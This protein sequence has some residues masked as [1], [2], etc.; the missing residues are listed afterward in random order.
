MPT[1]LLL[2]LASF[3]VTS[4]GPQQIKVTSLATRNEQ[5][6]KDLADAIASLPSEDS[7]E[8]SFIDQESGR[9]MGPKR[10]SSLIQKSRDK[11][12]QA[13]LFVT[14]ERII[15]ANKGHSKIYPFIGKYRVIVIPVQFSDVKFDDKAF[16]KAN[17]DGVSL[18]QDYIFGDNKNSMA[19][20]YQ[21]AS[22]GNLT[23]EGE[24]TPIIT[25]DKTLKN[26]GE[27]IVGKSDRNANGLVMDALKKLKKIKTDQAWWFKYDTW[28]LSDYDQDK[29]FHEPDGFIDAVV[30]IYAGKSQASCQY[31]FDSAGTRPA[32][33][34]VPEGPRQAVA[35]EC[36]DK[37]WPHRWNINVGRDD[38]DYS[39]SGPLVEG[40]TR[41]SM[42]GLK[43]NDHLFASDYNM[44]SEFSDRSTFIHEF[45]HS[46]S[47]P[48]VYSAGKGNSTGSWEVMSQNANLQA[49]EMSS[50]SKISLGWL[51]PKIIEQGE[52]TSAYLGAYNYVSHDQRE[53]PA[54]YT[55]PNINNN[56]ESILSV[57][58][59]SGEN[60]YRSIMVITDPTKENR[61]IIEPKPGTGHITAYSSRFNGAQRSLTFAVEVPATGE[62]KVSFDTIYHIET[63]T[64][65]VSKDEKIKVVT[66][67]DIGQIIINEK[68]IEKLRIVS[69]DDNYNTLNEANPKCNEEKVLADRIKLIA[70]KL[71]DEEKS[72][73]KKEIKV[74]QAPVWVNKSY[75]LTA[76][77][78]QTIKFQINYVTD[79]GYTEFGIVVDNVKLPSGEVIDFED[80]SNLG[81]FQALTDGNEVISFNQYYLMEHRLP[82]TN[83]LSD[84][85]D[86][87]YNMD[88]NIGLGE[89]SMFIDEGDTI[90]ERFRMV[91]FDYQPGVLVWYFNSKFGRNSSANMPVENKGKGYLLV[92]NSKVQE[93]KLPGI[94]S[95]ESLLDES[96]LAYPDVDL[97]DGKVEGKLEELVKVQRDIFTCF[98]Y[99][100]YATAQTGKA[101][102][103]ED[104]FKDYMQ[105]LTFEGKALIYRRERFNDILP[106]DRY[107]TV[108]VGKPFR[109]GTSIRTGLSTFRPRTEK[110]FSPFKVY[111][112]VEGQ[113]VLDTK[114]TDAATKIE[115]V[116]KYNDLNNSLAKNPLF[117]GDTVVVEKKGFN[118]EVVAPNPQIKARYFDNIDGNDNDSSLRAPRTKVYFMWK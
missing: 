111:K 57:V 50:Y 34:D 94:F 98:A 107:A 80:K 44:Q 103:C 33:A 99:T 112:E 41:P 39:A 97:T 63:E 108:S 95:D 92:V 73:L 116:A 10:R 30:L 81:D 36:F 22:L 61:K 12:D 28:D 32:S 86:A 60:V 56:D 100:R 113:M 17:A 118:F 88:N 4:C 83:Y 43:I 66:D 29:N 106:N 93:L 54:S 21:H 76:Y 102:V 84:G 53:N 70:G 117:H 16:F 6:Q 27:A 78:G 9:A 15:K 59:D 1:L 11:R 82:G 71:S 79:P 96:G 23:L 62:S 45:G 48:D 52:K 58:P 109:M 55:G 47:L 13:S 18:A 42:N 85:E 67:F 68:V 74:C 90:P 75:D 2:L 49:Q 105:S 38:V 8:E 114:M 51:A 7:S 20:Y 77:K 46:L 3:V 89:Q 26:Y 14:N 65:F 5:S 115:P 91:R 35:I 25:V 69:G 104:E 87:S 101:P 19:S 64:N 24:V 31:D 37:I 72:Q 40:V 110:A